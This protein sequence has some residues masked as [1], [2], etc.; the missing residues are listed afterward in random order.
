MYDFLT[1]IFTLNK[2]KIKIYF[3]DFWL[4]FQFEDN[5]FYH[6]LNT[7]YEVE[8]TS[9]NPDILFHSVDYLQKKEYQNF[10]NKNIKKIFFTGEN[11]VPDLN[12]TDYSL[13]FVNNLGPKNYRLPLWVLFINWFDLKNNTLRDPSY[14]L[15]IRK[16]QSDK[17]RKNL[18]KP[19][20]CSFIASK[21]TGKRT[22]FVPKLDAVKKVHSLGGLYSNSYLKATGR[23]D[24]KNKLQFMK[25]FKFNIAF[26][27]SIS[28]GY[29]TEKILHAFYTNSIPIYWG[30][31]AAKIDFNHKAFINYTDYKNDED[32]ITDIIAINNDKKRYNSYLKEPIFPNNQ[33]PDL[34]KPEKVLTFLREIIEQ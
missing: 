29:V 21:P 23:G 10:R 11:I 20:F 24:Q 22:D 26:E 3:A 27:N 31:N 8:V 19:F 9:N 2:K 15:E 12:K 28:D 17:P 4:N 32:L 30:S 5:Y 1:K 18:V 6:L 13:S 14:L 16:L 25:L 7:A 33:M 34:I